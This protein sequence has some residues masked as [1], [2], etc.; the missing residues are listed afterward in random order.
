MAVKDAVVL[1]AATVIGL[2]TGS[3]ELLLESVTAVPPVGAA[4]EIVMVHE[5][6]APEAKL[7]GLH[8]SEVTVLVTVADGLRTTVAD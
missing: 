8:T 1:L 3:N 4:A 2:E 5:V 7:V 6:V